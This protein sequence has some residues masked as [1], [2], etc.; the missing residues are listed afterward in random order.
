MRRRSFASEERLCYHR[1]VLDSVDLASLVEIVRQR[2]GASSL[3]VSE[4]IQSLWSGYGAIYRCSVE[5][6]SEVP[7]GS[8]VV[9]HVKPPSELNHPRGWASSQSHERKLRSYRVEQKFYESY[10]PLS[11]Q[12]SRVPNSHFLEENVGE[13]LFALEDLD[14]SGFSVRRH[15]LGE[16][17]LR[18]CVRWLAE[19]HALHLGTKPEGLW[20]VGTYWHLATRPDELAVMADDRLRDVAS[21][22]DRRLSSARFQT[23]VHGDAKVVFP[24]TCRKKDESR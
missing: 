3:E 2:L 8:V 10:A 16:A 24:M 4:R 15:S 21:A 22:I 14:A 19:F 1:R 7:G 9:K 13:W 17:Q 12:D 20:E 5:G 23:L 18:S 6:A 11:D